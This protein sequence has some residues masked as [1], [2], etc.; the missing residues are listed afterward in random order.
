MNLLDL[1]EKEQM[2]A[3]IP[4]FKSGDT[5]KVHVRIIEGQKE[6]IQVFEGVVIRKRGG[7]NR[8][9][10][11]VRKISRGVGVERTFPLHSPVI[12][13]IEIVTKGKVR[14]S[15]LYYLRGLRGKKARIKELGRR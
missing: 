6:R 15:R 7:N 3:D 12:D 14:R 11:T 2:R 10:F 8:A 4:A 5:V 13:K 9:S 1:L